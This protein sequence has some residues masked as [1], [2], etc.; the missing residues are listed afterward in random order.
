MGE[1]VGRPK[2]PTNQEPGGSK[3]WVPS[4]KS[5][6]CHGNQL[7]HNAR[8]LVIQ[9]A[10]CIS[11]RNSGCCLNSER[12]SVVPGGAAVSL[13]GALWELDTPSETVAHVS[14]AQDV[15]QPCPLAPDPPGLSSAQPL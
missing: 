2:A 4:G 15:F 5:K 9:G 13:S 3:C 10:R 11:A 7:G 14:R 6:F 1:A 8:Q 12:P